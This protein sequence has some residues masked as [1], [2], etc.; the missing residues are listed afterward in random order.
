M[1]KRQATIVFLLAILALVS[2]SVLFAQVS[3]SERAALIALYNST[4]GT[5]WKNSTNW[6]GEAGTE[7][8][9]KGVSCRVWD[10]VK[11]EAIP[12]SVTGLSLTF[13]SLSG[14]I[15]AEIGN[16]KNLET[17]YLN[18]NSLGG[19]IPEEIGSLTNLWFLSLWQN[20]LSGSIPKSIA[21]LSKLERLFLYEN[22]F[23]GTIPNELG[24]LTNLEYLWLQNNSL[25]GRIPNSLGNLKKLLS[26]DLAKNTLSGEIP[27]DLGNMENVQQLRLNDNQLSG[28]I[29]ATLGNLKNLEYLS[30]YSNSL[31]GSIPQELGNLTD[32]LY[33]L[34]IDR[35]PSI[36]GDIPESLGNLTGLKTLSLQENSLTGSIPASLGNLTKLESLYLYGNSL[37]GSI[38]SEIGNLAS[39]LQLRLN[40]NKL[41][42]SIPETLGNLRNLTT[43]HLGSN[44]LTGNIP[45]QLGSLSKLTSL[46]VFG[47][48][49]DDVIFYTTESTNPDLVLVGAVK[50]SE[51]SPTNDGGVGNIDASVS[52]SSETEI[53][54]SGDSIQIALLTSDELGKLANTVVS[55]FGKFEI[56]AL[57]SASISGLSS[58]QVTNISVDAIKGFKKNQIINLS[59]EAVGGLTSNQFDQLTPDSLSGLTK[60]NLGGLT[61]KVIAE[62]TQETLSNLSNDALKGMPSEEFSKFINE[63]DSG[64][65]SVDNVSQLL[66]SGWEINKSGEVKAPAGAKLTFKTL[67]KVQNI[68]NISLPSLPDLSKSFG[69]GGLG[70]Q[71]ILEGLDEAIDS[72]GVGYMFDQRS[73]GILTLRVVGETDNSS[74]T[75]AFLPDVNEIR[76]VSEGYTSGISVDTRGAYVLI[77]GKGHYIPLL[78]SLANPTGVKA[79]LPT[80]SEITISQGGQTV[81]S[82]LR[83]NRDNL[84]SGMPSPL[85]KASPKSAGIYPIGSGVNE[86]IEIVQENGSLQILTPAFKDQDGLKAAL[87]AMKEVTG[88]KFKTSGSVEVIYDGS[89][90]ILNPHFDVEIKNGDEKFPSGIA[91]E[92]GKFYFTNELGERQRFN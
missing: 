29:P 66:P 49:F 33:G 20:S 45:T 5:N 60:D 4:N 17:I 69:L 82:D 43:L 79:L 88:V 26:L 13:N 47:N 3:E 9:W 54:N 25:S 35:N 22:S 48:P 81:I 46:K 21:N 85:T 41:S 91:L 72:D 68:N 28:S 23:T 53:A 92:D 10:P 7:C 83:D 61:S 90:L 80:T 76:Q 8:E 74:P 78:P 15:P 6:L 31:S 86:K 84:I 51:K 32:K 65:I 89:A 73:D 14:S 64:K 16:L 30:L 56:E 59:K 12:A 63:L 18:M 2:S 67:K 44:S 71:S 58:E 77:T 70:S 19:S 87:F 24:N 75:A 42:G 55:A 62:I 40:N 1:A 36:S 52:G 57:N 38:P 34:S 39:L 37:T 50:S 11:K 27:K